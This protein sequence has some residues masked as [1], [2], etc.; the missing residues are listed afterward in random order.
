MK[1][2]GTPYCRPS[3]ATRLAANAAMDLDVEERRQ[4]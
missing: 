4:R 3:K 1:R 2:K